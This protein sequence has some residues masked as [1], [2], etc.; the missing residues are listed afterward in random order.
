MAYKDKQK[1]IEYHKKW[2]KKYYEENK[3]KERARIEQ[4]RTKIREWFRN[5]K[6]SKKC[7][8]CGESDPACLDFH[9]K[10]RRQKMLISSL[11]AG[12]YSP[13]IL[14]KEMDKCMV[15]CANY[16]RKIHA[17]NGDMGLKNSKLFKINN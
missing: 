10:H 13:K 16:H 9:H 15:V 17:H 11:Y 8:L 2:Y 14:L 4:R 12:G 7:Q 6:L 3:E 5:Y 1:Q